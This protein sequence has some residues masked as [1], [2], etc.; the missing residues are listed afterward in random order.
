MR[1]NRWGRG[2]APPLFLQRFGVEK[3]RS[4]EADDA[5]DHNGCRVFAAAVV[6]SFAKLSCCI[7]DFTV[8]FCIQPLSLSVGRMVYLHWL[9]LLKL[10]IRRFK[11]QYLQDRL[12]GHQTI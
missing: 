1:W 8:V 9:G 7:L 10:S 5:T 2:S 12:I 4:L 6:T 3:C 11:I